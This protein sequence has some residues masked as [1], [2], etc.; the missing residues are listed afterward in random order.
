LPN[1]DLTLT[2][3]GI[4]ILY[5]IT[6][7]IVAELQHV[8]VSKAH[9]LSLRTSNDFSQASANINEYTFWKDQDGGTHVTFKHS[10][11]N[12]SSQ[13]APQ[14]IRQVVK[15]SVIRIYTN[16][17]LGYNDEARLLWME[18]QEGA[19]PGLIGIRA[20]ADNDDVQ[21]VVDGSEEPEPVDN[22]ETGV[23]SNPQKK[24]F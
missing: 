21:S 20:M 6:T 17:T 7:A 16:M 19:I 24:A 12:K 11:P 15:K 14:R 1:Q 2:F 18:S 10:T 9:T 22:L 13:T 5:M 23:Q 3:G 8:M 4:D